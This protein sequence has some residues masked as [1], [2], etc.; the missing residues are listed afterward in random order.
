MSR[1]HLLAG[2]ALPCLL[3]AVPAS[4]HAANPPASSDIV[5]T[6]T[7]SARALADVPASVSVVTGDQLDSTP[8][9]TIDDVLRRVASVD[10]PIAGTN[11]QHPTNTIVSMRGLSGI[12][13]LV[14][15]TRDVVLERVGDR[16]R[17]TVRSC[18]GL[19]SRSVGHAS[20]LPLAVTLPCW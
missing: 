17:R 9:R 6:A 1:S 18:A 3:L 4:S 7:R 2:G 8:A 11:E 12:R 20:I 13:S 19:G 15:T 10:L 16:S 5:V 14:P